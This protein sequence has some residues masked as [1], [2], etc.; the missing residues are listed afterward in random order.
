MT[1]PVRYPW[2]TTL[3][4]LLVAAIAFACTLPPPHIWLDGVLRVLAAILVVAV[5]I[6][7][8]LWI[9]AVVVSGRAR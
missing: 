5:V 9:V 4:Y 7:G 2:R 3:W 8:L 1:E 6:H